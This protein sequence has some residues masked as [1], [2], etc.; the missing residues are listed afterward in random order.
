MKLVIFHG[1]LLL[2][3]LGLAF[4]T[5]TRVGPEGA[6]P[7]SVV[8]WNAS[9][10]DVETLSFQALGVDVTLER[11]QD[12]HGPYFW[13]TVVRDR[14]IFGPNVGIDAS[15]PMASTARFDTVGFLVG[16][17]GRRLIESFAR[18]RVLRDLGRVSDEQAA[19]YGL[20]SAEGSLV[21]QTGRAR[22]ELIVGDPV[23]ETSNRYVSDPETGRTYV[24][25]ARPIVDLESAERTLLERR[26]LDLSYDAIE[27]VTLRW[28]SGE[29]TM[30]REQST[31]PSTAAWAPIDQPTQPDHAFTDVMN[32]LAQPSIVD[33][34]ADLDPVALTE[35]AG[36]EY[37]D[38]GGRSVG[39]L[40]FFQSEADVEAVE[41]YVR[42]SL[43]RSLASIY[44]FTGENIRRQLEE[45]F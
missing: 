34:A 20:A 6:I 8:L 33:Y 3:A 36:L 38:R 15:D 7:G 40:Q 21:L 13:G 45:L 39:Y 2:A 42:S 41:F 1:L 32:L 12:P 19:E 5:W 23:W 30:V 17:D 26:P 11:R 16:E 18:L 25:D 27:R 28:P 24:V 43:T 9:P 14:S 44:Q 37:Y 10:D 22:R 35:V 29:R 31:N 4:Q